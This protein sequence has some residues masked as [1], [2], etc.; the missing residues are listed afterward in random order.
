MQWVL[1][2]ECDAFC[3]IPYDKNFWAKPP[4]LGKILISKRKT[5]FFLKASCLFCKLL[6]FFAAFGVDPF[7]GVLNNGGRR[8][9]MVPTPK[10][11]VEVAEA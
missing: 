8:K 4:T 10:V 11:E 6:Y 3:P 5:L 2:N 1:S 7:F 9:K